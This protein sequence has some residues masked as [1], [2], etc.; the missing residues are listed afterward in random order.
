MKNICYLLFL[1]LLCAACKKKNITPADSGCIT[2]IQRRSFY[3]KPADSIKAY[4]LLTRNHLPTDNLEIEYLIDSVRVNGVLNTNQ[5]I[6]A[7]QY[8]NGLPILSSDFGYLFKG[9]VYQQTDGLLYNNLM[10]DTHVKLSLQQV[11][12][13]F[14]E[15][16]TKNGGATAAANLAGGCLE[17][18]FGYYNLNALSATAYM[19]PN[20]VMVWCVTPKNQ[21]YPEVFIRDDNGGVV[22]YYGN[23]IIF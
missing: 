6:Y 17:A 4:N 19:V 23:R 21:Q 7:V 3:L 10:V 18:Q 15:E 14:L 12:S 1:V 20:F 8:L 22:A 9:G 2:Q 16:V 11:R 13:L 5:S